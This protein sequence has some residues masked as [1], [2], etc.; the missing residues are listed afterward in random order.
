[1]TD[2]RP[3]LLIV[4]DSLLLATEL[5][6]AL[7]ACGC[8][9]AGPAQTVADGLALASDGPLDGALLDVQL[10]EEEVWPVAD[11]LAARGIPFAV[12]TG[13]GPEV[14]PQRF[15]S[16]PLLIKPASFDAVAGVVR[17][18]VAARP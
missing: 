18:V 6:L 4:E 7:E 16:C 15:R 14:V 2:T 8:S 1:M 3:R 5:A 12:V 10:G 11:R 9:V 17:A 13:H